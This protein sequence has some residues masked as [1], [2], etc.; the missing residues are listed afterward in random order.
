MADQQQL[1]ALSEQ[2]QKLEQG[3]FPFLSLPQIQHFPNSIRRT[4]NEYSISAKAR[5]PTT[6]K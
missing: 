5:K 1:Q 6:R 2:Y 3:P 4:T